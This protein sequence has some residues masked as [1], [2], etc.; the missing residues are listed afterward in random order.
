MSPEQ[1][2][3]YLAVLPA[4]CRRFVMSGDGGVEIE[5][6]GPAASDDEKPAG[7]AVA[8]E[9]AQAAQDMEDLGLPA[10][11]KTLRGAGK[12]A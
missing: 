4:N 2:A 1:L 8:A 9:F 11:A 5:L 3:C 7:D 10:L 6:A 12:G